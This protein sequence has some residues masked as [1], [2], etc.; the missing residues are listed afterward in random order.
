MLTIRSYNTRG[1]NAYKRAGFQVMGHR[2]EAR[3]VNQQ[4]HDLIYMDCIASDFHHSV[5]DQ[6]V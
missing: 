2:R 3:R 1:L 6:M 4:A 5:L